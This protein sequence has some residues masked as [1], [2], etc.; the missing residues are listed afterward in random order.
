VYLIQGQHDMTIPPWPEAIGTMAQH[1]H[2]KSFKPLAHG[3]V[4]FG[5][6]HRPA[7]HIEEELKT[8]PAE[9]SI[10]VMHQMLQGSVPGAAACDLKPEWVPAHVKLVLLGDIHTGPELTHGDTKYYYTGSPYV[11]NIGEIGLTKSVLEYNV[12]ARSVTRIPL[13]GGRSYTCMNIMDEQRLVDAIAELSHMPEVDTDARPVVVI[14]YATSLEQGADRL[15]LAAGDRCTLWLQ[16]AALRTAADVR[17]A[18]PKDTSG[19]SEETLVGLTKRIMPTATE[20]QKLA[21]QLTLDLLTQPT[22][23]ALQTLKT[24]LEE[25]V[26]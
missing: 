15:R 13:A 16:P 17:F 19:H 2:G 5:L 10:L 14:T 11:C 23:T 21:L 1:V 12:V 25:P 8:V 6:D 18:V 20:D 4:F 7:G 24:K 9:A 3:P 22:E 26:T